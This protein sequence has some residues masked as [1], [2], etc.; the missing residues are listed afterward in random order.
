M[1]VIAL[2]M[3]RSVI[4]LEGVWACTPAKPRSTVQ[5]ARLIH[6]KRGFMGGSNWMVKSATNPYVTAVPAV[7]LTILYKLNYHPYRKASLT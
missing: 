5:Q 6:L 4:T 7:L 2:V 1:S 3:E